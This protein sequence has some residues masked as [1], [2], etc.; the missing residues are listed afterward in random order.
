MIEVFS[1]SNIWALASGILVGL[2]IK[3]VACYNRLL[4]K[5]CVVG[6]FCTK[7]RTQ[8]VY[9]AAS[10]TL[11][12]WHHTASISANGRSLASTRKRP[13]NA[14]ISPAMNA[15]LSLPSG[16]T[17]R[18]CRRQ[19]PLV[20]SIQDGHHID[21]PPISAKRQ[22][23]KQ[24]HPEEHYR[25]M[26][27]LQQSLIESLRARIFEKPHQC[28]KCQKSFKR[29]DHVRSHIK[30]RYKDLASSL[31]DTHCKDCDKRFTRPIYLLNHDCLSGDI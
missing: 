18:R 20:E 9:S 6:H 3:H 27:V 4:T 11:S 30:H 23:G 14:N 1:T 16:T 29:R 10:S 8:R 26:I 25:Q 15:R 22:K 24:V 21:Q 31:Y 7:S 2:K 12:E 17:R 13:G 28:P 19:R 5:S